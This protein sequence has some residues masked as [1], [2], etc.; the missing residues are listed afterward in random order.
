[1]ADGKDIYTALD[2]PGVWQR[3]DYSLTLQDI[4]C[5]FPKEKFS[6]EVMISRH[7]SQRLIKMKC[8]D[9][10]PPDKLFFP[11]T[12]LK[13]SYNNSVMIPKRI[14]FGDL[15]KKQKMQK[16]FS[17]SYCSMKF[18]EDQCTLLASVASNQY[19]TGHWLKDS[20]LFLHWSWR[21]WHWWA[22][23]KLLILFLAQLLL[24]SHLHGTYKLP[25]W[26]DL[27]TRYFLVILINS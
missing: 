13:D 11:S 21:F 12:R 20:E 22:K 24:C 19:P 5:L 10:S 8:T 26:C 4:P 27:N 16:W 25:L 2:N 1:M 3:S 14:R 18:S 7:L 9:P 23:M 15:K 17:T 6:S